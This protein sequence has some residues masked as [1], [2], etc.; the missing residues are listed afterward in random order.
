MREQV[1]CQL[2]PDTEAAE[3]LAKEIIGGGGT[4]N[5]R[6]LAVD[7]SQLL[8]NQLARLLLVNQPYSASQRLLSLQ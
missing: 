8:G 4:H 3:D 2:L 6:Q 7:G 1:E 5:F